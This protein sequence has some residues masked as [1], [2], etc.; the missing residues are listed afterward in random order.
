MARRAGPT[1]EYVTLRQ[2]EAEIGVGYFVLYRAIERGEL[3]RVD[4]H[5]TGRTILVRR[6]D[7]LALLDPN[8]SGGA[9]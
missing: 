1:S 7:V 4:S 2:A 6:A 8:M 3:K 5:L 9:R